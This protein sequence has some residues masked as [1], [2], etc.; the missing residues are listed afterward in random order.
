MRD[1][2]ASCRSGIVVA[3]VS[4]ASVA[5][6]SVVFMAGV[7][8]IPIIP[9]QIFSNLALNSLLFLVEAV[10]D[11]SIS[12][13]VIGVAGGLV[14]MGGG[15]SSEVCGAVLLSVHDAVVVL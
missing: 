6:V 7:S 4:A 9:A 11:V 12:R 2:I 14:V 5:G 1:C 13:G 8:G 3:V 15:A 10:E